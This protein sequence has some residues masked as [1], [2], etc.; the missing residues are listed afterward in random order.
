AGSR[1][2][3]PPPPVWERTLTMI[4]SR[5]AGMPMAANGATAARYRSRSRR[6]PSTG[7]SFQTGDAGTYASRTMSETCATWSHQA[8][9]SGEPR[10]AERPSKRTG[11]APR[12]ARSCRY[13][14]TS[15]RYWAVDAD[16]GLTVPAPHNSFS[17]TSGDEQ[18]PLRSTA[19]EYWLCAA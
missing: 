12:L 9:A 13:V 19:E 11:W 6:L 16:H 10:Y 14:S 18:P 8:T 3:R 15:A 2:L 17:T 5:L 1:P 7:P 4:P